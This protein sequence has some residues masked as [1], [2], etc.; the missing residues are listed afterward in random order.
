[1]SRPVGWTVDVDTA[2]GD[3][4]IGLIWHYGKQLWLASHAE[5]GPLGAFRNESNARAAVRRAEGKR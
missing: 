4:T 3:R 1:M 2:A 5:R